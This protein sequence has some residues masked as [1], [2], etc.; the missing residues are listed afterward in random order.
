VIIRH[1]GEITP[2]GVSHDP[3]ILKRV[4]LRA[5]EMP[6]VL[7]LATAVF[8]PGQTAAAHAHDG[9]VEIFL[10]TEGSGSVVVD[11]RPHELRQGTMFVCEPGEVHEVGSADG[12]SVTVFAIEV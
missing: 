5:G 11:G 12:M 7:Q 1:S 4:F 6:H 10:C 8:E 2:E 3:D 9:M